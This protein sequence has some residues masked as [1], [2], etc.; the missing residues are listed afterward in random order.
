MSDR[1]LLNYTTEVPAVKTAGEVQG[2]LAV[3]GASR[4]SLVYVAPSRDPV[5]IEFE[6]LIEGVVQ[7]IKLP[8]AV[9]TVQA[10]LH[11]QWNSGAYRGLT[12]RHTSYEH[13]TRVAWRILKS[14]LES[15]FAIAESGLVTREEVFIPYVVTNNGSTILENFRAQANALPSGTGR[16]TA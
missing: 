9:Q 1:A 13:A 3:A 12:Q 2:I 8:L 5:G 4:I 11:Q 14:W 7:Q 16:G 10:R 6:M 15:V